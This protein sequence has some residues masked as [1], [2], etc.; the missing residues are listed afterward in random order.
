[1]GTHMPRFQSFFCIFLHFFLLAKLATS[2]IRVSSRTRKY[3]S[4]AAAAT[5][6]AMVVVKVKV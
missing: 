3:Q 1:M 5:A 6:E 4:L 2:S